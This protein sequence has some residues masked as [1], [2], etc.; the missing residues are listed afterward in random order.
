MYLSSLMFLYTAF[1]MSSPTSKQ[2]ILNK[3]RARCNSW[4]ML[5]DDKEFEP[6]P[7]ERILFKSPARTTLSLQSSNSFPGKQ[8]FSVQSSGGVAYLTNQRVSIP[9]QAL[10]GNKGLTRTFYRSSTYQPHLLHSYNPSLHPFSTSRMR[11]FPR[12]FSD[13]MC[14]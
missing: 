5:A 8:P 9:N 3:I 2:T 11:T 10:T 6:L 1:D 4:V 7:W 14:G 13:P 12:H